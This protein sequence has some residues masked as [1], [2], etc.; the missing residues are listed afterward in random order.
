MCA[1]KRGWL[2]NTGFEQGEE[3]ADPRDSFGGAGRG[4]LSGVFASQ[5][6]RGGHRGGHHESTHGA[7]AGGF[8]ASH[9]GQDEVGNGAPPDYEE[10]EGS[11]HGSAVTRGGRGRDL[12]SRGNDY[13]GRG[14]GHHNN[15]VMGHSE[16][17]HL[18]TGGYGGLHGRGRGRGY[19]HGRGT[20][21]PSSAA[22]EW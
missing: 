2:G 21:H 4:G 14:R 3:S 10:V 13:F 22:H 8:G 19:G 16:M 18:P 15:P 17:G 7:L 1:Q 5:R 6:G 9:A 12:S 20:G 11:G